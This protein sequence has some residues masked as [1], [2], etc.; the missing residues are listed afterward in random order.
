MHSGVKYEKKVKS[1]EMIDIPPK[2]PLIYKISLNSNVFLAQSIITI[3]S[4]TSTIVKIKKS[5]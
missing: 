1:M 4:A 5:I 2:N 3:I